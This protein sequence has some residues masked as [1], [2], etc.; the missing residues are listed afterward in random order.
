MKW[1]EVDMMDETNRVLALLMR[2]GVCCVV[3]R[4][5]R[6]LLVDGLLQLAIHLLHQN[7]PITVN[8]RVYNGLACQHLLYIM[9]C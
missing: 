2:D 9:Q 5:K 4:W 8:N 6:L 3:T 1:H 7:L